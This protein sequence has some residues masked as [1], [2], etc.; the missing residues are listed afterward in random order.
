MTKDSFS[1]LD[2]E[3]D[4][5]KE[6]GDTGSVAE[7]QD[8]EIEE[9]VEEEGLETTA[10]ASQKLQKLRKELRACQE[11]S[12]ENLTKLQRAQADFINLRKRDEEERRQFLSLAKASVVEDLLPVLSSFESAFGNKQ[13]WESVSKEW[14]VGVEYIY[15]QL[16]QILMQHGVEIIEPGR[17]LFD[18][19]E[20]EAVEV[21]K[22]SD[23]AQDHRV[24]EVVQRGFRLAGK[25]LRPARVKV[26]EYKE[27]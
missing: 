11:E 7:P 6:N 21:V 14:R 9:S 17:I 10:T 19:R 25:L 1:P 23:P 27:D 18:P 5:K 13:A 16:Q 12:R 26:F 15:S 2:Q 3:F 22:T 4:N 20:H 8:V 24:A